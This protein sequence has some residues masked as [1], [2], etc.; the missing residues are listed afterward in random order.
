[1]NDRVIELES[2]KRMLQ[3]LIK[4]RGADLAVAEQ[5]EKETA[6]QQ[7]KTGAIA[8]SATKSAPATKTQPAKLTNV[9]PAV[10][11]EWKK[12]F[13]DAK[14]KS[15]TVNI[16]GNAGG[17]NGAL[18]IIEQV[19]SSLK[20]L[21]S[22]GSFNISPVLNMEAFAAAEAQLKRLAA[23]SS[24]AIAP[25]IA[26]DEKA[27]GAK[28]GSPVTALTKDEKSK[29]AAAKKQIKNW[30]EKIAGVQSRLDANRAKYE[31]APTSGL[32]GQITRDTNKLE[33]YQAGRAEQENIVK[34]LQGK[35]STAVK[36]AA[37]GLKPLTIDIIGNL[38]RINVTAKAPV[39][40]VVGELTK[41]QGKVSEAI[42]VNIKIMANQV[43]ASLKSIPRPTLTVD[44]R[45]NTKGVSQQLQTVAGQTRP[46]VRKAAK[47]SVPAVSSQ[48]Q[49]KGL[50]SQIPP[51]ALKLDTTAAVA[52]FEEFISL[53]KANS[54]QNI[55]LTSSGA[56]AG[57]ATAPKNPSSTVSGI[58]SSNKVG[59]NR[60]GS[61]KNK[62]LT[63]Q[64]R[65]AKSKETAAK[66]S[67]SSKT[68]GQYM[69]RKGQEYRAQQQ[70]WYSQ[71][72]AMYN[73]LF[74]A[75]PKPNY[76]YHAS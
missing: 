56:V 7:A 57:A 47:S 55:K 24:S 67:A 5:L 6:A 4:Q 40:P 54:L 35:T 16:R 76:G 68:G 14:S 31:Q 2:R 65:Y 23:L 62:P 46:V 11:R 39:V 17:P 73:R 71:Q 49:L 74:E 27:K 60:S 44:V 34:K 18:A 15:L 8:R 70:A 48:E 63:P 51:V 69:V 52:K 42:P 12:A 28:L 3:Q 22:L 19:Q 64:E 20:A 9:T 36:S 13:G 59:G 45:L 38:S 43:A 50:N 1:M 61:T 41:L 75:V 72:Q 58:V 30:N 21:Q 32:K 53:I 37:N 25:F 26:K 10:I 33:K 66:N 29:L